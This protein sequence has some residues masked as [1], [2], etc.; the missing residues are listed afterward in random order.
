MRSD[1]G[2]EGIN[3]ILG[4]RLAERERKQEGEMTFNSDEV[5]KVSH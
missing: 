1:G 4:K 2:H 5:A 3:V